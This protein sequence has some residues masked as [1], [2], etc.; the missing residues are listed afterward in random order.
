M[1][2]RTKEEHPSFGRI[3]FN[4]FTCNHNSFFGTDVSGSGG[5]SIEI[6]SAYRERDLNRDY[7]GGNKTIVKVELSYNQFYEA[8]GAMMNTEGMPC[9]IRYNNGEYISS[10][11]HEKTKQELFQEEFDNDVRNIGNNLN[12]IVDKMTRMSEGKT[13]KK[14]EFK[15]LLRDV[16]MARQSINSNLPFVLKQ[17]GRSLNKSMT[18]AK[19]GFVGFIE[20]KVYNLGLKELKKE[21]INNMIE[22]KK[23]EAN[24]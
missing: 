1:K 5:I 6:L 22:F 3:Q 23:G 18:E 8:I 17:F 20:S 7:I 16:E 11:Q 14:S 21:D 13:V 9:T 12:N 24:E 4:R 19:N 10:I 15:S 2:E